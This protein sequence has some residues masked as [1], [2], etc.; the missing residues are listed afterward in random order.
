MNCLSCLL[1][2]FFGKFLILS[3]AGIFLMKSAS[4]FMH[5]FET[6]ALQV[7]L[8]FLEL[9]DNVRMSSINGLG[10]SLACMHSRCEETVIQSALWLIARSFVLHF[11]IA[12]LLY[13]IL[14]I[15]QV[16]DLFFLFFILL[17]GDLST[18]GFSYGLLPSFSDATSLG[19]IQNCFVLP[20]IHLLCVLIFL[21]NPQVLATPMLID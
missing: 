15:L 12:K 7:S 18:L 14:T 4:N 10:E 5:Y 11:S 1:T 6:V 13:Q 9:S 16:L 20:S 8:I 3:A 2:D 21:I 17:Y 19:I